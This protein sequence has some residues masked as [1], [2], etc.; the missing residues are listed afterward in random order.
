MWVESAQA[1]H[2]RTVLRLGQGDEVCVFDGAGN[3]AFGAIETVSE[4]RL[5]IRICRRTRAAD[6]HAPR[7]V[8]ATAIPKGARAD[9]MIEKCAELGVAEIIPVCCGRAQVMPGDGKIARWRRKAD[10]A[11]KQSGEALTMCVS[12]QRG[13]ADAIT[14]AAGRGQIVYGDLRADAPSL[15]SVFDQ[16]RDGLRSPKRQ[17]PDTPPTGI[18]TEVTVF[19]GPEGGFTDEEISALSSAGALSARIAAPVLRVETAAVA[20]AALWASLDRG[21][22]ASGS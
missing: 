3:E 10:E 14:D 13:L 19:I 20:A 9:W 8:I 7:F 4:E 5:A 22:N 6:L 15:L 1:H 17:T 21:F 12:T 18:A 2:A 11:A 16:L